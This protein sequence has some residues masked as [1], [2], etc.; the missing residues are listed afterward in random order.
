[1]R[2]EEE[3]EKDQNLHPKLKD[4]VASSSL[5]QGRAKSDDEYIK[6]IDKLTKEM[7]D[8]KID[9]K[10]TQYSSS[11]P[12]VYQSSKMTRSESEYERV[13]KELDLKLEI[14]R[15][16]NKMEDSS[17]DV[18]RPLSVASTPRSVTKKV[19]DLS[20]ETFDKMFEPPDKIQIPERYQPDIDETDDE[21]GYG[22][23]E[24]S[25]DIR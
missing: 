11:L 15:V 10:P 16:K 5:E 3:S 7:F 19:H 9:K 8:Y 4:E 13:M 24:K 25:S 18:G 1:M 22:R 20:L 17:S 6:I 12:K 21:D 14:S 2:Q 23:K